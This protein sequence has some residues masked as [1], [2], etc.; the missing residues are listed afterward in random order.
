MWRLLLTYTF[1]YFTTYLTTGV[2][3]ILVQICF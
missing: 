2:D 3:V 1:R